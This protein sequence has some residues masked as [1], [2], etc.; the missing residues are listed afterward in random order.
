MLSQFFTGFGDVKRGFSFLA[1]NK[2][3]YKFVALPL[4][5]NLLLTILLAYLLIHFYEPLYSSILGKMGLLQA[6][7]DGSWFSQILSGFFWFISGLLHVF[8]GFVLLVILVV[9]LLM[10]S[11]I[12]NSPFYDLLSEAVEKTKTGVDDDIPFSLSRILLTLKK[13]LILELKKTFFFMGVPLLL[14][15][16]NFVP[17]LGSIFYTIILNF[18]SAWAMGYTYFAYPLGRKLVPFGSQLN[19]ALKHKARLMGFGLPLLIPFFNLLLAPFF[20]VGGTLLYLD[21]EEVS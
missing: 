11:Q 6:P 13:V 16:I 4:V 14:M 5:I 7:G 17:L 15:I 18:F 20:V 8:L 1:K 9:T 19:L 12:I 2:N 3:L 10:V 21:L